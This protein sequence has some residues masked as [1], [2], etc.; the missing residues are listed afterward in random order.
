MILLAPLVNPLPALAG[1]LPIGQYFCFDSTQTSPLQTA[2]TGT[3]TA[4]S[5]LAAGVNAGNYGG[6]GGYFYLETFEDNAVNTL[7][8]G[9]VGGSIATGNII[10]SVDAD[11]GIIDASSATT[12]HSYFGSGATGL[13][14]N[15]D[16]T[17]LGALPT[18]VGLVW[19]DGLGYNKITFTAYSGP[20]TTGTLLGTL[21]LDDIGDNSFARGSDEDRFF[22]WTDAGGIGSIKITNVAATTLGAGIGGS[23]IEV[24]HVQYGRVGIQVVP[25]P[26]TLALLAL[27]LAGLGFSRRRKLH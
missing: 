21:I 26:A 13:V 15:F 10:D 4:D 3:C 1:A 20:N 22:G 11:D 2:F 12:T 18:D 17:V 19:T 8:L 24:D 6:I 7:G 23:G 5:P 27:A 14:F 16:A 25:E 9:G